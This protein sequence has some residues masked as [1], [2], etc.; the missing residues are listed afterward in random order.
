MLLRLQ[1]V[2]SE[3]GQTG[4]KINILWYFLDGHY[5]LWYSCDEKEDCLNLMQEVP[6]DDPEVCQPAAF[7]GPPRPHRSRQTQ[8]PEPALPH[9]PQRMRNLF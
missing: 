2:V 7:Q 3:C 1:D 9:R 6:E 5:A 8:Q 4:V